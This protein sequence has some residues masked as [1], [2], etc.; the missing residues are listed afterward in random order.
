MIRQI[1]SNQNLIFKTCLVEIIRNIAAYFLNGAKFFVTYSLA[2]LNR[3]IS[4]LLSA[5]VNVLDENPD[6]FW[7]QNRQKWTRL[8][9]P[10]HIN[11]ILPHQ[12]I[13]PSGTLQIRLENKAKMLLYHQYCH[14]LQVMRKR[15]ISCIKTKN[16]NR[17]PIIY[18]HSIFTTPSSPLVILEGVLNGVRTRRSISK[19]YSI[20][21]NSARVQIV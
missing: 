19:Q 6:L 5:K 8:I 4:T 2:F 11:F 18:I 20:R 9:K 14:W 3:S 16:G 7:T 13:R 12:K 10:D 1:Q 15:K 17:K 21:S